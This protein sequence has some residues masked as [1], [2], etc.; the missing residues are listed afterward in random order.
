MAKTMRNAGFK[1]VVPLTGGL[2]AWRLAG[3][4]L[5][6]LK[7]DLNPPRPFDDGGEMAAMCPWP[8]KSQ[9]GG[10]ALHRAELSHGDRA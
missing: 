5:E 2:D 7:G 9:Q 4:E 3:L 6:A 8:V 10:G 1:D